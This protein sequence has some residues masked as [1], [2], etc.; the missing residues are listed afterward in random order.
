MHDRAYQKF[1]NVEVPPERIEIRVTPNF[2]KRK[3]CPNGQWVASLYHEDRTQAGLDCCS[4]SLEGAKFKGLQK[5]HFRTYPEP[6][7]EIIRVSREDWKE[8]EGL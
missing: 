8:I 2:G 6:T 3:G 4:E 1:I 5:A 7:E